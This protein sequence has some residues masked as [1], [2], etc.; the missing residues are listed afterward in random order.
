[1]CWVGLGHL[2]LET[3]IGKMNLIGEMVGETGMD[4]PA[5]KCWM[6]AACVGLVQYRPKY[7][8]LSANCNCSFNGKSHSGDWC[9]QGPYCSDLYPYR[10]CKRAKSHWDF[11]FLLDIVV[12]MEIY[13]RNVL[14][15]SITFNKGP[16]EYVKI[17]PKNKN[18]SDVLWIG[19]LLIDMSLIWY[20]LW[21][22]KGECLTFLMPYLFWNEIS[23]M[24]ANLSLVQWDNNLK[25]EYILFP[26][27]LPV[28]CTICDPPPPTHTHIH[29]LTTTSQ[30]AGKAMLTVLS[31]W[32]LQQQ[33]KD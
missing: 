30:A 26:L 17:K 18:G 10:Q 5:L 20:H 27:G 15:N 6:Q 14:T 33:C 25:Y 1:M 23:K 2:T 19:L 22:V 24:I 32:L 12:S 3:R 9:P 13:L 16:S 8:A 4:E 11:A 28:T 29:T 21:W 7:S 31:V